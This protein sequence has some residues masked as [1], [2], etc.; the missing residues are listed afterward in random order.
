MITRME[1]K[2][3]IHLADDQLVLI[4]GLI[5]VLSLQE[6]FEVKG[7]S[8]DG[9]GLLKWF[10]KEKEKVDILILDINMPSIGG[11]E[12]LKV[13]EKEG[14]PCDVIVLSSHDDIKLIKQVLKL[15]AKG[16][17]SKKCA[18]ENIVNAIRTVYN[19][20]NYISESI[21]ERIMD[22]FLLGKKTK[23]EETGEVVMCPSLLTKRELE[24]LKLI[25]Q[26]YSGREISQELF[27][28]P[29]TVE[30][31]RKNLVKKLKVKNTIGLVKF[32]LSNDLL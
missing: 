16:Y 22:S 3:N 2:I 8:H 24:V 19:G 18:G 9:G 7:Y 17:L 26:E 27:I 30:T 32:A 21:K 5:A 13:F 4:D 15:G 6:D 31:H 20:G 29:N 14:F 23:K 25:V 1:A 12:V 10:E 28:T 11:I